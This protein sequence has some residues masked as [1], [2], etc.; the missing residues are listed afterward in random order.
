MTKTIVNEH[1]V[2]AFSVYLFNLLSNKHIDIQNTWNS[3][4][5]ALSLV[6]VMV[7]IKEA[8]SK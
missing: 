1:M 7:D 5:T 3:V 2:Y 4:S 6:V 8:M